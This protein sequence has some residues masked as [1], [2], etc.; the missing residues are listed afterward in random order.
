M[1]STG[2]MILMG[3]IALLTAAVPIGVMVFLR[4]RGGKWRDFL[5]GAGTFFLF[6]L[7]LEQV[8]HG[9]VFTSP[10]GPVIQGNIWLYGLYGGLAAGVFEEVGRFTA[11][12]LL[13]KNRREPVTALSYGIGHGGCEAFLILGVTY[14]SN[15]V[16]SVMMGSGAQMAPEIAAGMEEL[17]AMP[18]SIFLWAGFE[19]VSAAAFH[20]ASSV[21]VFAA[22]ARPGKLWLFPAAIFAHFAFDFI[23]CASR[24]SP[25]SIAATELLTAALALT[26]AFAAARVYKNLQK[27]AENT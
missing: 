17:A 5:T 14:I 6:A 4:R 13:L 1:V 19:R 12:K 27:S 18:P 16:L 25:M 3:A 22:A 11:F 8:L 9:L 15:I 21:L 10:L 24:S 26:A 7:V 2:N 20:M 23:Y